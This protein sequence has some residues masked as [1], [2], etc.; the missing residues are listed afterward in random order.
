LELAALVLHHKLV[1]MVE[2]LY[3]APLLLMV[4]V[5]A[6]VMT[7]L[8]NLKQEVVVQ[9]GARQMAA[10]VGQAIRHL[11]IHPKVTMEE[12]VC[13]QPLSMAV[14]VVAHQQLE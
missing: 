4:A 8:R 2:I 7:L 6:A 5:V 9:A 14:A 13:H 10:L 3:L 11:Q 1:Q 12:I